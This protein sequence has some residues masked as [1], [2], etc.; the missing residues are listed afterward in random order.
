MIDIF[1]VEKNKFKKIDENAEKEKSNGN[2][3]MIVD[4]TADSKSVPLCEE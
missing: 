4:E 3:D 2:A 1:I